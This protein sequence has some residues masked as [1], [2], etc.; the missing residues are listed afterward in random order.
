MILNI[1]EDK[2]VTKL[3]PDLWLLYICNVRRHALSGAVLLYE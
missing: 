3:T 1:K 2:C